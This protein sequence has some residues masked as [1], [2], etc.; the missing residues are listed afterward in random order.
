MAAGRGGAMTRK[1]I[2]PAL[3]GRI[4]ETNDQIIGDIIDQLTGRLSAAGYV[5]AFFYRDRECNRFAYRSVVNRKH[6]AD[7]I[8]ITGNT[9][10]IIWLPDLVVG[11]VDGV[12]Y[13]SV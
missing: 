1:R 6:R 7:T 4:E 12:T 5:W 9:T 10:P 11:P 8:K 3:Y 2:R 13:E